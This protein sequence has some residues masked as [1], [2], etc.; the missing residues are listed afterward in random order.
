MSNW[1]DGRVKLHLIRKALQFRA[2]KAAQFLEGEFLRLESHG[3]RHEHIAV[4]A[5]RY[6]NEWV[7]I[8]VPRWLARARY[9]L[10]GVESDQFWKSTA[11]QLENSAPSS[12]K[13]VLTGEDFLTKSTGSMQTLHAN[14]LL[15]HFPVALLSGNPS[16]NR[17][18]T[19]D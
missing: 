3:E 12:W 16:S 18:E 10:D 15:K 5:R 7:L 6:G 11:I 8:V 2:S 17:A 1:K 19:A 14:K 13:S 9:P 4:F